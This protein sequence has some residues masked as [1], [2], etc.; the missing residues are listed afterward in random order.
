MKKVGF[1]LVSCCGWK[2][3]EVSKQLKEIEGIGDVYNVFG[4]YDFICS[5]LG[6][7]YESVPDTVT[8]VR[9]IKGVA[10]T[11]VSMVMR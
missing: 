3:Y 4:E 5:L 9:N 1:V 6:T 7:T 11:K 10:D 2:L 8:K